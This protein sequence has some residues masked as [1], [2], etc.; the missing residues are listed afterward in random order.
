M[1]EAARPDLIPAQRRALVL[2]HVRESGAASIHDLARAIGAST[3][4]IRRDLEHLQEAGFLQR[5][6][7]GALLPRPP[8]ATFEPAA[9]FA[10]GL[11]RAQKRA[12][13]QVAAAALVAGEAVIFDSSSTVREAAR[14]A[15]ER[16]IALT[17]V[18]NDLGT[19]QVLAASRAIRV[20]VPGGTLRPDSLTLLGE[21]GLGFLAGVHADVALLG[22]HAIAGRLLTETSLEAAAMKRAMISAA[23][24]AVVLADATKFQPAAF[25]TICD[26]T[27]VQQVVTDSGA[28]PVALAALRELGVAAS[29]VA[30]S[31][32]AAGTPAD[33]IF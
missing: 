20:V 11:A 29:A 26:V 17:A 9:S 12:I 19:A 4:T 22:V 28:D 18:T 3:S 33:E 6:H 24:R 27:S 14:A 31:Q 23:R 16:G 2:H 10:A 21:P 25:C 8:Q 15:V 32:H 30:S 7:G 5:S 13:G 1:T